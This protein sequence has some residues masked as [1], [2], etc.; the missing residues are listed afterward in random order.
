MGEATEENRPLQGKRETPEGGLV[1]QQAGRE[2]REG[3]LEE[4]GFKMIQVTRNARAGRC[5]ESRRGKERLARL[6]GDHP[7]LGKRV[8]VQAFRGEQGHG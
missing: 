3:F 2:A 1:G 6:L 5:H 4:V 8:Q 7:G